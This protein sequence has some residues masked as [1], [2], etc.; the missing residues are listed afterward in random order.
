MMR[1]RFCA[2]VLSVLLVCMIL[3]VPAHAVEEPAVLS[4]AEKQEYIRALDLRVIPE[5]S[6]DLSD[7]YIVGF[8]VCAQETVAVGLRNNTVLLYD[9]DGALQLAFRFHPIE[10]HYYLHWN[11]DIL[12]LI[13]YRSYRTYSIDKSGTVVDVQK[14]DP[15]TDASQALYL[16]VRNREAVTVN[17]HKYT[18]EKSSRSLRLF[19]GEKYDRLLR[20]DI[21]GTQTVFFQTKN[22]G[23][24][25]EVWFGIAW[26]VLML[27]AVP[28]IMISAKN[29][30]KKP[31]E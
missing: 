9:R 30:Y 7:D 16:E 8:D 11:G 31:T 17:A 21:D 6:E 10:S 24:L 26:C 4:E 19:G 3:P 28:M 1:K 23:M 12:E 14:K 15:Y 2:A 29:K 20:T 13:F 5:V 27:M 22:P 18:I 25:P